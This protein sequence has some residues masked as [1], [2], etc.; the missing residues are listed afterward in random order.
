MKPKVVI[1]RAFA[2]TPVIK[3][4][5]DAH[6]L[7]NNRVYF[8]SKLS[9]SVNLPATQEEDLKVGACMKILHHTDDSKS[10]PT[11]CTDR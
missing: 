6:Q 9:S 5:S 2:R 4:N 11:Q 3:Q 1:P 10:R 7:S 8:L